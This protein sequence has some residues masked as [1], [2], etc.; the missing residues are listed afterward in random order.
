MFQLDG[1]TNSHEAWEKLKTLYGITN[2]FKGYKLENEL[3]SFDPK[4][5]DNIHDHVTKV[6][7]LRAQCK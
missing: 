1:C 2:E 3:M 7:E 6:N 4:S 5:F